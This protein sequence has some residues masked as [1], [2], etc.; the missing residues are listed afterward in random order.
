MAPLGPAFAPSSTLT[1]EPLLLCHGLATSSPGA[2]AVVS[3]GDGLRLVTKLAENRASSR[4]ET[5]VR[6]WVELAA[7]RNYV[8]WEVPYTAIIVALL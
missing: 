7:E 3:L 4:P 8:P 6:Q 5:V 2:R 1:L